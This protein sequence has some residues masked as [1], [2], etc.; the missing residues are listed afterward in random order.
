[1]V[2]TVCE[3]EAVVNEDGGCYNWNR[4]LFHFSLGFA[5]ATFSPAAF[6]MFDLKF[7]DIAHSHSGFDHQ[8][9]SPSRVCLEEIARRRIQLA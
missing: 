4:S 6:D 1:M 5:T 8:E 2:I 9:D 3:W 7:E